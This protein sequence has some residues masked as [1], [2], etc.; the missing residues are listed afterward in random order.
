MLRS[1][2]RTVMSTAPE[3]LLLVLASLE[4][5][6][7]A[8]LE[9]VPQVAEVVDELMWTVLLPVAMTLPKLQLSEPAMMLQAPASG[10]PL[11]DQLRPALAGNR[12]V[13]V[14]SLARPGPALVTVIV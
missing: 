4:A 7:V 14:T 12:S 13:R 6:V 2:Q 10:P 8:V 9:T 1:G 3:E 5:A 11:M